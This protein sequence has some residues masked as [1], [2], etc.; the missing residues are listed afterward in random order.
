MKD[1]RITQLAKNLINYS[2]TLQKG[3][4]VL[5]ENIGLTPELTSALVE[6]AYEAGGYPYVWLKDNR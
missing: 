3:E 1:P 2:V 6:A 5:I 4:S